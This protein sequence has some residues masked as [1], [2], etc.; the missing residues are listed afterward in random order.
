M[1]NRLLPALLAI[2]TAGCFGGPPPVHLPSPER[3][4]KREALHREITAQLRAVPGTVSLYFKDLDTDETLAWNADRA[5]HAASLVTLFILVETYQRGYEG[6]LDLDLEADLAETYPGATDGKAF[7]AGDEEALRRAAGSR[8]TARRLCEEMIVVS[9]NS[10]ANNLM[11]RLGGPAAVEQGAR[12]RGAAQ[13]K[14]PRHLMD[15]AAHRAGLNAVTTPADVGALLERL[16]R[17]LV[18]SPESS[19]EMARLLTRARG[20]FLLR[21]LPPD[22][23]EV[24]HKPGAIA[25]VR[26]DAGF[27]TCANGTYVLVIMMQDLKDEKAGETAGAL[28]SRRCYDYLQ[29]RPR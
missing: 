15:R 24:A 11:L 3:D 29:S 6:S 22:E 10:A 19:A 12:T 8:P 5:F 14:V 7:A 2:A 4:R 20:G 13:T 27:V 18:V 28:L 1:R 9:S 21:D 16:A 17:R 25:G 23:V 26:H